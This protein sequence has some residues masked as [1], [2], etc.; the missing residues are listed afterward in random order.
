MVGIDKLQLT[1]KDFKIRSAD[2][3]IWGIN[4]NVKQG[5]KE[6]PIILTTNEKEDIFANSMY[7]NSD[8]VN[9]DVNSYGLRVQFSPSKKYH[10]YH[11]TGTGPRLNKV[12]G[13]VQ[14]YLQKQGIY[15]SLEDMQISRIDLT[16]QHQMSQPPNS[17]YEVIKLFKHTRLKSSR[18]H[19]HSFTI[20]NKQWQTCAYDKL[21]ELK[22]SKMEAYIEG[23]KNLLRIENRWLNSK[24]V[25]RTLPFNTIR[26]LSAIDNEELSFQYKRIL[27]GKTFNRNYNSEQTKL[28]LYR[29]G[30]ILRDLLATNTKKVAILQLF[31]IIENTSID[32]ALMQF[33]GLDKF[34]EFL[35]NEGGINRTETYRF[36]NSLMQ[37]MKYQTKYANNKGELTITQMYE[38][39]LNKFVA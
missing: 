24:E 38:E 17:Y 20:G 34:R 16:D 1:T 33:G 21:Q 27:T 10:T 7:H 18:E 3:K 39:V 13:E 28:D 6:P 35:M 11:L 14:E 30:E 2:S 32:S 37:L 8:L 36:T 19:P 31:F 29:Q 9:V 26:K 5:G 4:R 15:C 25:N 22:E 12:V 23:E